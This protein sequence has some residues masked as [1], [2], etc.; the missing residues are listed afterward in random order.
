MKKP[1]PIYLFVLLLSLGI[2]V[3]AFSIISIN[4][5]TLGFLMPVIFIFLVVGFFM[6]I[7]NRLNTA[8]FGKKLIHRMQCP[9]CKAEISA[10]SK[11]CPECGMNLDEKVECD[12]CGHMNSFDA[13]VCDSCNANLK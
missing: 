13:T 12:Y 10:N 2:F 3:F 1:T 5:P 11:F 6:F 7:A 4:I 8:Q 9:N